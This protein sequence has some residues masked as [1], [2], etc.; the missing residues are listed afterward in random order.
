MPH[1]KNIKT[2]LKKRD[3]LPIF[4]IA[5]HF[6]YDPAHVILKVCS[7]IAFPLFPYSYRPKA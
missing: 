1:I 7:P 5:D 4:N 3:F 6:L 2:G